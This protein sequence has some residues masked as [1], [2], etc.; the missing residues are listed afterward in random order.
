[1][2]D[3]GVGTDSGLIDERAGPGQGGCPAWLTGPSGR[4]SVVLPESD[5]QGVA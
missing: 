3:T 5:E 1:M 4:G 2:F